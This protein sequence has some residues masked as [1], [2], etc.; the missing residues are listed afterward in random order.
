M[1][2]KIAILGAT[3]SIGKTTLKIINENKKKL[4]V[5]LLTTNRNY[6]KLLIDAKK[7]K[8]RNVIIYDQKVLIKKI[9]LFSKSKI[10]VF[11]S[12][13]EFKIRNKISL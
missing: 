8:V 12:L 13:N 5:D 6:K 2:K 3:G 7:F 4:S 10:N 1:K 11:N 9:D